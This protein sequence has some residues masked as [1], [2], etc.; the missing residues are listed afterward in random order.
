ML[1]R[2]PSVLLDTAQY[3]HSDPRD[4]P[5]GFLMNALIWGDIFRSRQAWKRHACVKSRQDQTRQDTGLLAYWLT[6]LLAYWLTGLLAYWL[7]GLLAYRLTGL[8]AYWLT[9][10]GANLRR[11]QRKRGKGGRGRKELIFYFLLFD[12]GAGNGN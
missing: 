1:L 7:T 3:R 11:K 2:S 8:L 10:A 12:A 9:L 6:G 4:R 5:Q